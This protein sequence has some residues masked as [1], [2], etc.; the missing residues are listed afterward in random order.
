MYKI[1]TSIDNFIIEYE[2]QRL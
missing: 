1:V 2:L